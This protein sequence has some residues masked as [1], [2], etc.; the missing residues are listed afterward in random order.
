MKH[1]CLQTE[2]FPLEIAASKFA[3][4]GSEQRLSVLRALVRS[5]PGG[6]SIGALGDRAG[7]T[8]STLTHHLRI[9]TQAG[10]VRQEKQGR[11]IICAAAAYEEVQALCDFLLTE[12]CAECPGCNEHEDHHHG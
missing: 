4:L 1:D 6:L 10:L 12:C 11:S 7:V 2:D 3:A 8:G 9:L 5:G